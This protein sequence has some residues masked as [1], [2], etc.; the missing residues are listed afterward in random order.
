MRRREVSKI[1]LGSTAGSGFAKGADAPSGSAPYFARTAVEIAASVLPTNT[2]Y[3]PGNPWRYGADGAGG[4]NDVRALATAQAIVSAP[5]VVGLQNGTPIAGFLRTP[6]ETAANVLPTDYS[7]QVEPYDI[8]REGAKVDNS[9]DDYNALTNALSVA[10][11]TINAAQGA[12][13]A[14][15]TGV[16]LLSSVVALPNRVRV[17]GQN[18]RGSCF[19]AKHGWSIGMQWNSATNYAVGNYVTQGGTLYIAKQT[20]INKAPSN[21]SFWLAISKALFYANNG[22]SLG[23]SP[24]IGTGLSMFDSTLENV[25]IDANNTAGLGCV[26]SSAWQEDCGLRGVLLANFATYGVRF[27]D[28]FGGA[29]LAKIVDTEIFGGSIQGAIGVDLTSPMGSVAAFMLDVANSS[30]TGSKGAKLAAGISCKG[31]SL[32]CRSV[33]FEDTVAGIL[34]DGAGYIS[35][36]D[37]T[38]APT[39]NSLVTIAPTFTGTL[40]MR[41]CRRNG[42]V[43]FVNDLRTEGYGAISNTDHALFI[44]NASDTSTSAKGVAFA[45]AWCQFD[46]TLTGTN[47]PVAGFNVTSVTRNGAGN[48]TITLHRPMQTAASAPIASHNLTSAGAQVATQLLTSTTFKVVL[49]VAG[50]PSDSDE[51]KVVVFGG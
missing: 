11:Q 47:A 1:L 32:L 49:A 12:A 20:N 30:I 38:G 50:I 27:Q 26:L 29:A 9:A 45:S 18:K 17:L 31:N 14:V 35:L 44:V 3:P 8:R 37:L 15:P 23:P 42:A 34:V 36:D 40:A 19:K 7:R 48:Y 6:A 22:F 4:T 51:V 10:T 28:G 41:N 46:G 43:N 21:A 5:G 33:H 13:I 16:S 24:P 2:A 39:V 25:S